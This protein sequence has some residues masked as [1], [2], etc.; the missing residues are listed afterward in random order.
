[1]TG[2]GENFPYN[3]FTQ[4]AKIASKPG[5]NMKEMLN[6]YGEK[7]PTVIQKVKSVLQNKNRLPGVEKLPEGHEI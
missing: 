3:I 4:L 6:F 7:S 5:A 2:L 1:M